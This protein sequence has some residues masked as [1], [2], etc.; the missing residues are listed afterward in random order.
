MRIY[1]GGGDKISKRVL[2]HALCIAASA[3]MVFPLYYGL[4]YSL[5]SPQDAY[6][7][8]PFLFPVRVFVQNYQDA[9]LKAKIYLFIINS[10]IV[11]S[12]ITLGQLLTSSLSAYAFS[13]FRFK[14]RDILFLLFVATMMVPAE[15]CLIPN[16]ITIRNLNLLDSYRGLIIPFL[17]GALG[18]FLM[19]QHFL[20]IPKEIYEAAVID[21]AGKFRFLFRILM[22]LSLPALATLGIYTFMTSWNMYTW[23][24]II[25][26]TVQKRTVQIGIAILRFEDAMNYSLVLAG[27]MVVLTPSLLALILGQK[28]IIKGL[29]SG[30]I[31]G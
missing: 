19:R 15:A 31:K 21:G 16:Y 6:A 28:Y 14:G 25:T 18:T 8:P 7:W 27:V 9:W 4:V 23:P 26:N 22:P 30:A 12:S 24:L 11:A 5:L 13:F 1:A 20:T 29:T 3:I 10:I 2:M 17:A